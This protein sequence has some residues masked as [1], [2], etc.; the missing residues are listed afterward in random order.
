MRYGEPKVDT[1]VMV[2][3]V[4]YEFL[5]FPFLH[6]LISLCFNFKFFFFFLFLEGHVIIS[7]LQQIILIAPVP[8]T[9]RKTSLGSGQ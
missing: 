6:S 3:S 9:I 2:L 7:A 4:Y 5:S 8:V 1:V